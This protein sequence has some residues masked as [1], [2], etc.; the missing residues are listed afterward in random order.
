VVERLLPHVALV[1]PNV[2]EAAAIL[3][4]E[5]ADTDQAI[6]AAGRAIVARGASAVLMKGGHRG[7]AAA[8]DILLSDGGAERFESE[9][10]P[11]QF[12]GTGCL[13]SSS[14]AALLARGRSLRDAVAEA[15]DFLDGA[16][17]A[18]TEGDDTVPHAFFEYYGAEGLPSNRA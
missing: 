16:L 11:G 2:Q 8:V 1:T 5:I 18:A 12:R 9:R 7:G 15:K 14:I 4:G 3:G 6:E 10:L 13:L 17:R